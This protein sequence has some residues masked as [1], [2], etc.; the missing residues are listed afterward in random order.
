[1]VRTLASS[2]DS[3]TEKVKYWDLRSDKPAVT[4]ENQ[5]RVYAMDT[6]G[7][8][9]VV[10]TADRYINIIDLNKPEAFYK[11]IQSPLKF[12]TRVVSCFTPNPNG[13]AIG[14]IEGRCAIQYVEERD[15]SNNF[16]FK[17]HR[18]TNPQNKDQSNVY[19]VNAISFHPEHGTFST[20]GSDGQF[21]FWDGQAKHRLS[22]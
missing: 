20:A 7:K 12:Q 15:A 4:V 6:Q 9:L 19:S 8:L 10:G 14:S 13:F 2:T 5:E 22:T 3:V 1:M 17:C 18:E 16:S 11:T 21:N